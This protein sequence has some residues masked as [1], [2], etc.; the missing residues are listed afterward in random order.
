[1]KKLKYILFAILPVLLLTSCVEEMPES[2][3]NTYPTFVFV[4][5]E[6]MALEPGEAYSEP[7]IAALEGEIEL[8][9]ITSVTS[10][11]RGYSGNVVGSDPDIYYV[12]YYAETSEGFGNTAS[13]TVVIPPAPGDLIT[14]ISGIYSA[15]TTRITGESY[16]GIEVWI[17]PLGD[18]KFGLSGT[19][20]HFYPDGRGNYDDA[21]Y[22]AAGTIITVNDLASGDISAT[23]GVFP[24]W[25]NHVWI[26]SGSFTVNPTTKTIAFHTTT[27][28]F[29]AGDWDIVMVQQ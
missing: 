19:T 11:Y 25:G 5:D 26:K 21:L 22:R 9:V 13:R 20:A 7:G 18:N 29:A 27:D 6:D 1:M 23:D 2:T 10:K 15:T 17:W 14:D 28:E 3:L 16:D 24:G 12:N 8:E 4:G